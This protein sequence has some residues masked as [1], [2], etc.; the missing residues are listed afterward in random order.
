MAG[1]HVTVLKPHHRSTCAHSTKVEMPHWIFAA[2]M[3][4]KGELHLGHGLGAAWLGFNLV[5]ARV[6]RGAEALDLGAAATVGMG[7]GASMCEQQQGL[8]SAD[9]C[10]MQ[11]AGEQAGFSAVLSVEIDSTYIAR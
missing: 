10:S 2:G 3:W 4:H 9:A 1:W 5:Q 8:C 11:G 6:Q 7:R